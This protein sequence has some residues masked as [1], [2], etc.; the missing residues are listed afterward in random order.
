MEQ[1]FGKKLTIM[2]ILRKKEKKMHNFEEEK[3]ELP[4]IHLKKPVKELLNKP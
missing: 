1:L 4:E 2:E 3:F